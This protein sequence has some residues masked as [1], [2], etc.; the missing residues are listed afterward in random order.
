MMKRIISIVAVISIVFS[1]TACGGKNQQSSDSSAP[2]VDMAQQEQ[3]SEE[4]L[5]ESDLYTPEGEFNIRVFAAA[6]GVADTV[7][8]FAAQGLQEQ[9]GVTAIVNNITGASGAV[10]AADLD[11]YK[12]SINEL[13]VV[14]MSLFTMA[15]LMTPDLNVSLDNYEIVG[16]LIRDEFVLLVSADSGIKSWEDLVEYG[17]NNQII[18]ASNAPGGGT[19]IVQTAL[20]GDAGLDA[21]ALTSDGSNKDILAVM[22][23]DAICTSATVTLAKSYIDSGELIPIAIF[24]ETPY[25]GFAGYEAVPTAPSLG[26]D[27]T[28]PSYNFIITRE[29]VEEDEVKGLY[30]AILSYRTTDTF[31]TAAKAANYTPDNTDGETLRAEI[32]H[33]VA[34]CK[35]IY[36]K[37]YN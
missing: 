24:S 33:Y 34:V 29:G 6:G 25:T 15:P 5:K 22:S 26:F 10:A 3:E 13:A 16:S 37:Y 30:N 11:G 19:H 4:N 27:I 28:V 35:D 7:T 31:K 17:K 20:F 23:G 8:R 2:A 12:P 32:E 1:L 14:S 18:Y 9:Y 21:Q 36:D